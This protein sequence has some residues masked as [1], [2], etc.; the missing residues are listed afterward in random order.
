MQGKSNIAS[1]TAEHTCVLIPSLASAV[2]SGKAVAQLGDRRG[3]FSAL[4]LKHQWTA[5]ARRGYSEKFLLTETPTR[6]HPARGRTRATADSSTPE[7]APLTGGLRVFPLNEA[8]TLSRAE[9]RRLSAHGDGLAEF[10]AHMIEPSA[11]SLKRFCST[12]LHQIG[13]A[14]SRIPAPVGLRLPTLTQA[15]AARSFTSAV[16]WRI[17][18]DRV[19]PFLWPTSLQARAAFR[20][21]GGSVDT[22]R[23]LWQGH[24]FLPSA[25]GFC[26]YDQGPGM[27]SGRSPATITNLP[28]LTGEGGGGQLPHPLLGQALG[29]LPFGSTHPDKVEP[30]VCPRLHPSPHPSSA[31]PSPRVFS[32]RRRWRRRV[33]TGGL[34]LNAP[35]SFTNPP[36]GRPTHPART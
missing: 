27:A 14:R 32:A 6:S 5:R 4:V 25:A 1:H 20:I 30:P 17:S 7:D 29:P 8:N 10:H 33:R 23:S 34:L 3:W 2:I 35:S 31:T 9:L 24:F 16:G 21:R 28:T 18:S 11:P 13:P 15:H 36:T 12:L 22:L 26:T 19:F